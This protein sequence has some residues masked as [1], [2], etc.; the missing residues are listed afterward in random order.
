MKKCDY[1]IEEREKFVIDVDGEEICS[2]CIEEHFYVCDCCNKYCYREAGFFLDTELHWRENCNDEREYDKEI[3][4]IEKHLEEHGIY[5]F[6]CEYCWDEILRKGEKE[7][8]FALIQ[9]KR[10]VR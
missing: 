10:G 1:C 3:Y 4:I 2:E 7:H 5:D 8:R 6:Y 9:F